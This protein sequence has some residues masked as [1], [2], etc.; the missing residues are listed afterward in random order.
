[1]TGNRGASPHRIQVQMV[2]SG[3]LGRKSGEGLYSYGDGAHREPDPPD[4]GTRPLGDRDR[5][6]SLA[7]PMAAEVLQWI[8]AQIVNE[9]AFA[10][11]EGIATADDIDLTLRLGYRWPLGPLEIGRGLG[12]ELVRERLKML[13]SEYGEAYPRRPACA[14][15]S[16]SDLFGTRLRW[17]AQ[18]SRSA[19]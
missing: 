16:E 17:A 4:H 11:E 6:E 5:L 14:I 2:A 3:R 18:P 1:M 8:G 7:G 10:L 13:R 12:F 19:Q 15:W 9:A